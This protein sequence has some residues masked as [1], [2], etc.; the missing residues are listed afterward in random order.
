MS[1]RV[2]DWNDTYIHLN[3]ELPNQFLPPTVYYTT[4]SS[5]LDSYS[6]G[7]SQRYGHSQGYT[8]LRCRRAQL[9]DMKVFLLKTGAGAESGSSPSAR[10]WLSVFKISFRCSVSSG[11]VPTSS[12]SFEPHLVLIELD[13]L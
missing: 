13:P 11:M 3:G 7:H 12:S 1:I 8:R 10:R 6:L 9:L 4:A 5:D 2:I